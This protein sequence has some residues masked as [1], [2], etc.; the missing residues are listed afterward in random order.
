M[1]ARDMAAAV[2]VADGRWNQ[3][4]ALLKSL[5]RFDFMVRALSLS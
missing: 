4:I 3:F 1:Y 5:S 2:A